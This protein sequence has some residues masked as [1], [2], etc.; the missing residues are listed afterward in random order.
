MTEGVEAMA[1]SQVEGEGLFNFDKGLFNEEV[2]KLCQQALSKFDNIIKA[3]VMF[4]MVFLGIALLEFLFLIIFITLLSKS[5]GLA[6]C[7]ALLF[8]TSFTYF[9]LRLYF[10]AQKPEQFLELRDQ[11]LE[12]CKSLLNYQEV[13]PE[14]HMA[15]ASAACRFVASLH[16]KEYSFY[17][18]PEWLEVF[19]PTMEKFSCWWHWKDLHKMKE[20]MLH[21]SVDEHIKLVKCEPTN[22]EVHATLANAYVILSSLYVD[23]RK[24]EGFDEDRWIPQ[25]QFSE[26]MQEKFRA[27]AERAI[28]EFRILNDYA[29]QDPWVHV[30]LA[31]SYHDLQMP[32]EEIREYEMILKLRPNDKE[33]LFKLGMLYFQQGLNAKGLRVYEELKHSHYKKA[34]SLIK[35]YGAYPYYLQVAEE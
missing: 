30:Q 16:E 27:T 18:P 32:E 15:L 7:L 19:S 24:V 31:Y 35:F 10:Q 22:L 9:V 17:K 3:Y 20:L 2:N 13:I 5:S 1:T 26:D 14:H 29:P 33:T 8:L 21:A 23:P 34:E 12:A 6:I 11:Y 25:E 28:E 4:N